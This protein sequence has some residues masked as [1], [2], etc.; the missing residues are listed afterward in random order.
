MFCSGMIIGSGSQGICL[1]QPSVSE[2]HVR[3]P[4]QRNRV[5]SRWDLHQPL[6]AISLFKPEWEPIR[7]LKWLTFKKDL[8]V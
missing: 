8:A 1:E 4:A 2:F 3:P 5:Y 6:A 7:S